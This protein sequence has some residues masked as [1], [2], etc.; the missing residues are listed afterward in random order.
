MKSYP[1][2]EKFL[3][4]TLKTKIGEWKAQYKVYREHKLTIPDAKAK[5]AV[6]TQERS[7]IKYCGLNKKC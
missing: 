7:D 2:F 3:T 5:E 6:D 4:E 1:T